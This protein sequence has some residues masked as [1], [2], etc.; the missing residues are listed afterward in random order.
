MRRG[1]RTR[2]QNGAGEGTQDTPAHRRGLGLVVGASPAVRARSGGGVGIGV[3]S[4]GRGGTGLGDLTGAGTGRSPMASVRRYAR[5]AAGR[6]I[7]SGRPVAMR[8][9]SVRSI[10]ARSAEA[11]WWAKGRPLWVGGEAGVDRVGEPSRRRR[12]E[13]RLG[14]AGFGDAQVEPPLEV[15]A[16]AIVGGPVLQVA[17]L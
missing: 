10:P 2:S 12:F 7:G 16:R 14:S 4:Y 5:A 6:S 13:C 11:M 1:V 3:G 8:R 15:A 9:S 17:S